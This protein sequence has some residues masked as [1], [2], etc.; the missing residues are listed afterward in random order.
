MKY[1]DLDKEIK[2][3]N[4]TILKILPSFFVNWMK[5]IIKQEEINRILTKYEGY[6]GVLS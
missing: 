4:S 2:N 1:V 6:R 5:L 3:S